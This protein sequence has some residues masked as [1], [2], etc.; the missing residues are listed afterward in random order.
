[1]SNFTKSVSSVFT[2][3]FNFSIIYSYHL[4]LLLIVVSLFHL[5]GIHSRI[6]PNK[7]ISDFYPFLLLLA[8][9]SIKNFY[10]KLSSETQSVAEKISEVIESF[11]P[12]IRS[13]L[14]RLKVLYIS[15]LIFAGLLFAAIAYDPSG[16]VSKY[17]KRIK[18][19][20]ISIY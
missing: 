7:I 15:M 11:V 4:V 17:F 10:D 6:D 2:I 19:K 1:M 5:V 13:A 14:P 8:A 18:Q 20:Y 3:I 12:N 16:I 9:I